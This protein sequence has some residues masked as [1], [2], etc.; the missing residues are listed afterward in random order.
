MRDLDMYDVLARHVEF[1]DRRAPT[2]DLAEIEARATT[3]LDEPAPRAPRRRRLGLVAV[4]AAVVLALV[5]AVA[6]VRDGSGGVQPATGHATRGPT[7]RALARYH[8]SRL[9]TPPYAGRTD[10]A[11]VWTGNELIVWGG[12]TARVNPQLL[13]DVGT[14]FDPETG[15]WRN[16]APPPLSPRAGTTAA[17]TGHDVFLW[18]GGN[19]G[20]AIVF[21]DGALYDPPRDSWRALPPSPLSARTD[22]EAF[23]TGKEVIVTGGVHRIGDAPESAPLDSAA[24]NPK[25]NRWRVLPRMPIPSH[26]DVAFTESLWIGTRLLVWQFWEVPAATQPALGPQAAGVDMVSYDPR[27]NRWRTIPNRKNMPRGV[28]DPVWTGRDVI[29]PP[30]SVWCGCVGLQGTEGGFRYDPRTN[31]WRPLAAGP[32]DNAPGRAVWT[33]RALVTINTS[34]TVVAGAGR[35]SLEPGDGAAYD[36]RT[37][38]WYTLRRPPYALDDGAPA[39]VW[40]GRELLIAQGPAPATGP[41]VVAP[42]G[43][44]DGGLR[45]GP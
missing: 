31:R 10:T 15:T 11:T 41:V 42:A 27:T 30:S 45:L 6:V 18:G 13:F 3:Q 24:Y 38:R 23:W 32:L 39:I 35:D 28:T 34:T 2:I 16:L 22:A 44:A 25:T 7:A 37:N 5:V 33:G 19:G 1:L 43:E 40:T 36:P 17:W 29:V 14:A 4:A 20:P 21:A 8:W 12:T 26:H 9:P